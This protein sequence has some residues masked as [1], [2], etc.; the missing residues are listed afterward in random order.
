[1]CAKKTLLSEKI[2]IESTLK[3][4]RALREKVGIV[5]FHRWIRDLRKKLHMS[6]KQLAKR[7]RI[8]Q[9]K[10]SRIEA[11]KAKIKIETLEKIFQALFCDA[12]I[13]PAP[14]EKLDDLI[15][16]QAKLAAAKELESL[17]GSMALEEQLP[18]KAYLEK[19]IE[20]LADE[21]IRS[22][23]TKIWDV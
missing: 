20:E 6:Q 13:L 4:S 5:S 15:K 3:E 1:M 10:L 21:L 11:G 18:P 19:K 8:S 9:P 22:Q 17:M 16:K 7:A 23:S 12:M 2:R 14:Q